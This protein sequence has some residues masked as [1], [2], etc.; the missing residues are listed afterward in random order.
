M[1]S[2]GKNMSKFCSPTIN[3]QAI[4]KA[5]LL[6]TLIV[7][8]SGVRD[9]EDSIRQ[10]GGTC[11]TV[12]NPSAEPNFPCKTCNGDGIVTYSDNTD[13]CC[14]VCE[15]I[16]DSTEHPEDEL[17]RRMIAEFEDMD[18]VLIRFPLHVPL[19]FVA[20]ITK[21]GN[22]YLVVNGNKEVEQARRT[23]FHSSFTNMG[24]PDNV[25][26][27]NTESLFQ[28]GNSDFYPHT[29]DYGP[30][31][32]DNGEAGQREIVDFKYHTALRPS[33]NKVN[34]FLA[35]QWGVPY[36]EGETDTENEGGNMCPDGKGNCISTY[37]I[38]YSLM[39]SSS[40][41]ARSDFSGIDEDDIYIEW[42]EESFKKH[43]NVN[44][45]S[46]ED[47][48]GW[49]N[50]RHIDCW[51]KLISSDKILIREEPAFD[52]AAEFYSKWYTVVRIKTGFVPSETGKS[53]GEPYTNSLIFNRTVYVPVRGH[54]LDSAAINTYKT[55]MPNYT[56]EPVLF[57]PNETVRGTY[58]AT[59]EKRRW[60]DS[61]ALHCRTK[62]IP[63]GV[64]PDAWKTANRLRPPSNTHP[65]RRRLTERLHVGQLMR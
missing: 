15:A 47:E 51:A 52:K 20:Q 54:E 39:N 11:T 10:R 21:Q 32:F 8:S 36:S 29:R 6:G 46:F 49:D 24:N 35:D 18:G 59:N 17:S 34:Q 63:V 45:R 30:W 19:K 25:F 14:P 60:E 40:K 5:F 12:T 9:G 62:E 48:E 26:C 23:F 16:S 44:M 1:N 27:I 58:I 22:V 38:Y 43:Y 13:H 42:I 37:K 50:I 64:V 65:L 3:L 55:A 57:D 61:D 56:I 4:L 53:F 2:N 31:V 28:D 33:A 41:T 7:V